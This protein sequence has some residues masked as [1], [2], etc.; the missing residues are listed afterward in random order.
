MY[1]DPNQPQMPPPYQFPPPPPYGQPA[2][3]YGGQQPYQPTQYAPP[4]VPSY[5]A[6]PPQPK[7]SLRWLWI[8]LAV[9]GGLLV[10]ACGGCGLTLYIVGNQ[11]ANLI[12]PTFAATEYY[13]GIKDHS[14]T[15]AYTQLADNATIQGQPVTSQDGFTQLAQNADTQNGPIS[16]YKIV[17]N[18]S[19]PNS[20]SITVTVTRNGTSYDVHLTLTKVGSTWKIS[21]ADGI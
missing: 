18:T 7:K 19:D 4:P 15:L 3:E 6:P 12:G 1:N 10:L 20:G 8:T 14:Y 2:T 11:T 13:Q 16:S 5:G 21:Q 9:V 17:P